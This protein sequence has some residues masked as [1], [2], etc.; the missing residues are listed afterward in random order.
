MDPDVSEAAKAVIKRHVW[1]LR[2]SVAVFSLF[3]DR[4]TEDQ[5]ADISR[6]LLETPRSEDPEDRW[7]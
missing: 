1:Y 6:K 4:V 5:K 7:Y 2:P 3:S